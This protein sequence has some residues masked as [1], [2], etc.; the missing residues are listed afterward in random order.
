[1]PQTTLNEVVTLN[2]CVFFLFNQPTTL[3][4]SLFS[5]NSLF[6]ELGELKTRLIT[7]K[8]MQEELGEDAAG[9][10]KLEQSI[11]GPAYKNSI[12]KPITLYPNLKM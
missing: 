2:V 7:S 12:R 10:D 5:W 3:A 6:P 1:M 4:L 9:G 8:V 11:M